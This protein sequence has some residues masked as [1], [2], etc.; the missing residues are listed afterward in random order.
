V[1]GTGCLVPK[2]FAAEGNWSYLDFWAITD[3]PRYLGYKTWTSSVPDFR[4]I[5]L[6]TTSLQFALWTTKIQFELWRR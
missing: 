6:W 1:S 2:P 5:Q 4:S 3:G